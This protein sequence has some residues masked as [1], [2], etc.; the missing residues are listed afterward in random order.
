[1]AVQ[2]MQ[3]SVNVGVDRPERVLAETRKCLEGF[4]RATFLNIRNHLL[5]A[6]NVLGSLLCFFGESHDQPTKLGIGGCV[7]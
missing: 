7:Q 5:K 2:R 4:N 6:G 3:S 1:M